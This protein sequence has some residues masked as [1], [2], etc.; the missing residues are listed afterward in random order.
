M[1]LNFQKWKGLH[2]QTKPAAQPAAK[3][4]AQPAA[5]PA[6]PTMPEGYTS[7]QNGVAYKYPFADELAL[8]KYSFFGDT[9]INTEGA[10]GDPAAKTAALKT[11]SPKLAGLNVVKKDEKVPS[12]DVIIKGVRALLSIAAQSGFGPLA[13]DQLLIKAKTMKGS[14]DKVED[15]SKF[16]DYMTDYETSSGVTKGAYTDFKANWPKVWAAQRKAAGLPEKI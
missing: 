14:E 4:A 2:E 8:N 6:A 9:N 12:G 11:L 13:A 3:P 7:V 1:I 5:K 16:I 10:V 15:I